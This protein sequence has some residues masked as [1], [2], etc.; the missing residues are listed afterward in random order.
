M[1]DPYDD[2]L[3]WCDRHDDVERI[4]DHIYAE[5]R[6]DFGESLTRHTYVLECG[7]KF[8]IL[9]DMPFESQE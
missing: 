3:D 1:T 5:V 4:V 6:N 9:S 2:T 8:S 7:A